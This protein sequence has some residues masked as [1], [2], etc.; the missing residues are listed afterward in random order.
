MT[1]P[2]TRRIARISS[3]GRM[4]V[5]E[6]PLPRPEQGE[7]LVRV[8]R[9]LI[10]PGT[11]LQMLRSPRTESEEAWYEFGYQNAGVIADANGCAGFIEGD[12]VGCLGSA[13]AQHSDW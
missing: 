7:V 8:T 9:S 6:V 2:S 10:S 13:Y 1:I 4:D 3:H 12:R 11:E 5:A